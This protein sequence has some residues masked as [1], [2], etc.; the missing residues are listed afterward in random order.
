MCG[1]KFEIMLRNLKKI[2]FHQ[3]FYEL[4]PIKSDDWNSN[5]LT[6]F[7]LIGKNE[8]DF[9]KMDLFPIYPWKSDTFKGKEIGVFEMDLVLLNH[10]NE[11]L[12]AKSIMSHCVAI[13]DLYNFDDQ[14]NNHQRYLF[15]YKNCSDHEI[16]NMIRA[17]ICTNFNLEKL[18][19]YL[20]DNFTT[21]EK[22]R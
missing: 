3:R 22:E 2:F 16:F 13:I 15:E 1:W 21:K 20:R 12:F 4:I 18:S 7:K 5:G 17:N 6:E 8:N 11:I 14:C 10:E 19:L 9:E